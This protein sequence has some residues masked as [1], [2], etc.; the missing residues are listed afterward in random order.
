MASSGVSGDAVQNVHTLNA[1]GVVMDGTS[2]SYLRWDRMLRVCAQVDGFLPLLETK[3]ETDSGKA[4]AL[5]LALADGSK[6]P[7]DD[8]A[9]KKADQLRFKACHI[10]LKSLTLEVNDSLVDVKFGDPAGLYRKLKVLYNPVNPTRR[11]LLREEYRQ[12]VFKPSIGIIKH[13]IQIGQKAAILELM[14]ERFSAFDKA[15]R[16]LS[17]VEAAGGGWATVCRAI[18]LSADDVT[19]YD[20]DKF[21]VKLQLEEQRLKGQGGKSTVELGTAAA[22]YEEEKQHKGG[23]KNHWKNKKK[24]SSYGSGGSVG[25]G[26]AG[27]GAGRSNSGHG[28]ASGGLTCWNCQG[29]GHKKADCPSEKKGKSDAHA[30]MARAILTGAAVAS[31]SVAEAEERLEAYALSAVHVEKEAE[32]TAVPMQADVVGGAVEELKEEKEA[33]MVVGD[34]MGATGLATAVLRVTFDS[35]ATKSLSGQVHLFTNVRAAPTPV[36]FKT[37][38]S[39]DITCRTMG[40]IYVRSNLNSSILKLA[41][42]YLSSEV[43]ANNTLLSI[44]VLDAKGFSVSFARGTCSISDDKGVLVERIE[45]QPCG[46]YAHDYSVVMESADAEETAFLASTSMATATPSTHWLMHLRLAHCSLES[47]RKMFPDMPSG[48]IGPCHG[49]AKG[50]MRDAPH[51][52]RGQIAKKYGERTFFDLCGPFR[53]AMYSKAKYLLTVVDDATGTITTYFLRTRAQIASAVP[54]H[55][56]RLDDPRYMRADQEFTCNGEILEYCGKRHINVEATVTDNH[57]ATGKV[58]RA[59]QSLLGPALALLAHARLPRSFLSFAINAVVAARDLLPRHGGRP[60]P[61]E[62]RTGRSP[63]M[64]EYCAVK[65]FGCRAYAFLIPKKR[66]GGKHSWKS[67]EGRNLGPSR[68]PPGTFVL[69]P[70]GKVVVARTVVCDEREPRPEEVENAPEESDLIFGDEDDM[71]VGG[72]VEADESAFGPKPKIITIDEWHEEQNADLEENMHEQAEDKKDHLEAVIGPVEEKKAQA[73]SDLG[74]VQQVAPAAPADTRISSL[75]RSWLSDVKWNEQPAAAASIPPNRATVENLMARAQPAGRAGPVTRSMTR[76]DAAAVE[77]ADAKFAAAA[78]DDQ[79]NLLPDSALVSYEDV[80]ASFEFCGVVIL[81]IAPKD[82]W[83]V[84]HLRAAMESEMQNFVR[85]KSWQDVAGPLP[86]EVLR[87]ALPSK[88]VLALKPGLQGAPDVY[89]ARLCA[90]GHRQVKAAANFAPVVESVS[91]RMAFALAQHFRLVHRFR[92]DVTAAFLESELPV[93]EAPIYMKLPFPFQDPHV[94]R[95][96]KFVYGLRGAPKA[97]NLRFSRDLSSLGYVAAPYDP[98]TFFIFG[99]VGAAKVLHSVITLHVDDIYGFDVDS[100]HAAE[101]CASL[102]KSLKVKMEPIHR[103]VGLDI[104]QGE[105]GSLIIHQST[106]IQKALRDYEAVL[107]GKRNVATPVDTA[108]H[109]VASGPGGSEDGMD[110]VSLPSLLGTLNYVAYATRVDVTFATNRASRLAG[111]EG[112]DAAC[113][114]LRY[115]KANPSLGL[116][117]PAKPSSELV[118]AKLR[119]SGYADADFDCHNDGKSHSGIIVMLNNAIIEFVSEKQGA[120]ALSTADAEIIALSEA[121]RRVVGLINVLT[122]SGL[123]VELP[124]VIHEDN[125]SALVNGQVISL[126]KSVRHLHRRDLYVKEAVESGQVKIVKIPSKDQLADILTKALDGDRISYLRQAM[127][128]PPN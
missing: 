80:V 86:K 122:A 106:F 36:V 126:G 127:L 9:E 81:D 105:D 91:L 30:K 11:H 82:A 60:S 12:F 17:S 31:V 113:R 27:G 13:S 18:R 73:G 67:V 112:E 33:V 8:A 19:A 76:V 48:D 103:F 108:A 96:R 57:G 75:A 98:C 42:V 55:L 124:A 34:P 123:V 65:V 24:G 25:G 111:R 107:K 77:D 2:E 58:E 50:K 79:F 1:V 15:E 20:L 46:L 100:A 29:K 6:V 109:T 94:V 128:Y 61:F 5:I 56:Q 92:L 93:N 85:T 84:P 78:V 121:C 64:K 43:A 116:R 114:V 90:G 72:N 26:T 89:K 45:R 16:L 40:D 119:V 38:S 104:A 4:C 28:G 83:E 101:V 118:T 35:G 41:D 88:W 44:G 120:V 99:A 23:K 47:L 68:S 66:E 59:H 39:R 69:L 7:P 70:E 54:L 125:N 102:S 63:T 22:A 49:C 51:R 110:G 62:A 32:V 74:G 3:D 10:I 52:T 97:W 14:G 115:L 71:A 21:L 53:T 37:A 95:L 117:F 87:G